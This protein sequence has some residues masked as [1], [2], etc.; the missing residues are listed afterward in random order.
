MVEGLPE[1]LQRYFTHAIA[2]G[3]PLKTTVE[4]EMR[5]TFLLGDRAKFQTYEMEA[6]QILASPDQFVWIP[7]LRSGPVHITGSDALVGGEAWTRF[8]INSLMPD[9]K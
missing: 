9:C 2:P 5:G 7:S 8:W 6:R 1:A 4:L 3:T